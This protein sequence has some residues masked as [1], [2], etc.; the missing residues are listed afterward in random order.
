MNSINKLSSSNN[1]FK[2]S[3][4]NTRNNNLINN[5]NAFLSSDGF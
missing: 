4:K 3:L 2:F 1:V 5:N